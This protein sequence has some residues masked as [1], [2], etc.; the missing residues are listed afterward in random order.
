MIKKII[1]T[2][3]FIMLLYKPIVYAAEFNLSEIEQ[4]ISPIPFIIDT[5]FSSDFDDALA[6]ETAMYYQDLGTI[7]IKGIS[8]E[9]TS[10]RGAYAMNALL[11]AHHRE[12]IPVAVD[13]QNGIVIGSKY[14]FNMSQFPHKEEYYNNTVS[15]YRKLLANTD[16][17]INIITLGQIITMRRLLESQ[18]DNYSPLTGMELVKEKVNA[19]YICGCK[20]SGAPENNM[21]YV[22]EDYGNN[23]WYGTQAAGEA[24]QFIAQNWPSDIIFVTAEQGGIFNCGLFYKQLDPNGYDLITKGMI[25]QGY[26]DTGCWSFDMFTVMAAVADKT[27]TLNLYRLNKI[28]GNMN[29]YPNGSSSWNSDSNGRHYRLIKTDVNSFYQQKINDMLLYEYSSRH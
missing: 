17:P 26:I 28:Q 27:N 22:G 24:G 25:D 15:F 3:L 23:R 19:I 1:Y 9:C 6:I 8:L 5:D 29:I 7:D 10:I 21:F 2:C 12:Y 14:H 4:S 20:E 13:T 16:T 18:P 11:Q